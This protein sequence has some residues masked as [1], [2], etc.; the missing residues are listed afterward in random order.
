[1]SSVSAA[2]EATLVNVPL[3]GATTVIVKLVTPPTGKEGM[4]GQV[5]VLLAKTQAGDEPE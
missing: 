2:A 5:T 4:V 3:A 1:M